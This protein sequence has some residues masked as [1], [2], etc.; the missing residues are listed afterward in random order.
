MWCSVSRGAAQ[1]VRMSAVPNANPYWTTILN[2]P[3]S[4]L[5]AL[6]SEEFF[7][8]C[9]CCASD[10]FQGN[11]ARARDLFRDQPRVCGFA[12]FSAKRDRRKIW[13]IGFDHEFIER[14]LSGDFANLSTV[15]EGDDSGKRNEMP[16][17]DDFVR[18]IERSAKTMKDAADLPA[19]IS[20]NRQRIVPRVALMNYDV[21]FQFHRKIE[22]LLEQ[23]RLF[24]FV[25]AV[26]NRCFDLFFGRALQ[27]I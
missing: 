21:E 24:R 16:E 1:E 13:A 11:A 14:H 26:F 3:M 27:R 19:I 9:R 20:Q 6:K 17:I 25:S 4:I 10:F 7:R 5:P 8:G 2:F 23:F 12:P 18:L 15:F 22:K